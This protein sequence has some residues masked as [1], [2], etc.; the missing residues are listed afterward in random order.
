[1]SRKL[2]KISLIIAAFLLVIG[3]L[4]FM[5]LV[6]AKAADTAGTEKVVIGTLKNTASIPVLMGDANTEY[7]N[8]DA[9]VSVKSYDTTAELNEAIQNG[10]VNAAVTD[11]VGYASLV[12]TKANAS[13]KVVG[14]L[15]GYRGL[16]ANKKYKS[17]KSLKGKTIAVDKNNSSE[18]YLKTVLKK[19][20]MK[21]SAVKIKQVDSEADRVNSLKSGEIDAA[22][23]TDPEISNAKGN[24]AKV[25]SK[26]KTNSTN[27]DVFI[28]NNKFA[29]KN[30]STTRILVYVINKEI[31]LLNKAGG[32]GMA[33]NVLQTLNNAGNGTKYLTKVDVDFKTMHKVKKS[34]FNKAFKYAKSQ[35]LYKGKVNYK[36]ATLK[37]DGVKK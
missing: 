33:G 24:G 8:N 29:S 19:N 32:Y 2:K 5:G 15:P 6:N 23:L 10:T 3:S 30:A 14:T 26:Q 11:L 28:I 9:S 31:K 35:K 34:D 20:K 12:N 18:Q 21:A 37:V 25:L 27:G 36:K 13:W 7:S 16:V 22:V 1:M 4:P 17:V